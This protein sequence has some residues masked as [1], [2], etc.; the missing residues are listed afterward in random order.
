MVPACH[1]LASAT[2]IPWGADLAWASLFFVHLA[3]VLTVAGIELQKNS[4]ISAVF[5]GLIVVTLPA[6]GLLLWLL[7]AL[8]RKK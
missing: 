3:I 5:W 6:I 7:F 8:P 4:V 2:T 1:N